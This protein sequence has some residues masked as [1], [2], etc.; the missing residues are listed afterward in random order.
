MGVSGLRA[1]KLQRVRQSR[2]CDDVEAN[3][4]SVFVQSLQEV[5]IL[6]QVK[7]GDPCSPTAKEH[8]TF[9]PKAQKP[10]S[11]EPVNHKPLAHHA[12]YSEPDLPRSSPD[13]AGANADMK[14]LQTSKSLWMV[15][16]GIGSESLI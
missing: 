3:V 8:R 11:S 4:V 2:I 13:H 5:P 9:K 12:R 6:L 1:L 14:A 16:A 15:S 7:P 10:L